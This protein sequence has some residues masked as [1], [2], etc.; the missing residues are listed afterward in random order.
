MKKTTLLAGAAVASMMLAT[1]A[2][3]A[4]SGPFQDVPADHW[5]Y[6]AVDNLQKKKIVIGYPDG[7]YGGK[8]AMTRYEFAV[9]IDRLLTSLPTPPAVNL[10]GYA[11]LTDLEPYAKKSD[12]AGFATKADVDTLRKLVQE[13]ETELTT[14]GVDLDK[15]KK[16]VD[17]LEGRVKAIETELKR[18]KIGGEFSFMGRANHREGSGTTSVIDNDGYAVTKGRGSRGGLLADSRVLHDLDL[19]VTAR[20]SD[21]ATAFAKINFGNY[22]SYLGSVGSYSG[23]RSDRV[24]VGSFGGQAVSQDQEQSVINAYLKAPISLPGV[25]G[26]DLT[27]GR[28]PLQLSPYTLK[29]IDVDQYFNNGKTDLGDIP[30]D[31]AKASLKL[32]P[33]G[34][35]GFAAKTDPI[36]YLSNVSGAI[37]GDGSYGLY[38]GAGQSPYATFTTAAASPANPTAPG[39]PGATATPGSVTDSQINSGLRG[40]SVAALDVNGSGTTTGNRPVGSSIAPNRNGA[41]AVEQLAGV[42]ASFGNE[43]HG[44]LGATY[45]AFAG[46]STGGVPNPF[47]SGSQFN[48]Q[49]RAYF[50]RVYLYGADASIN[51]FGIGFTGSYTQ[52][53][54]AGSR[55]NTNGSIDADT[56]TKTNRNNYAWDAAGTY[57]RGNFSLSA[58]YREVLPFFGAPGYWTRVGS[59]TNPTDIKGPY[60]NL[61]YS[62]SNNLALV[63]GGQFYEGT[64]KAIADGGLSTD[65]KIQNLKAGLKFGLTS[66]SAVDL[67]VERTQYDVLAAS[68][69]RGKP[70][71]YFYNIGYGYSF[72]PS[73]SFK[74]LYQIIRYHDKGTGFD[75]V[76]GNGGVAAAQFAVKF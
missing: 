37:T 19:N 32:G 18:V 1:S 27:I 30:V 11:K 67:G 57:A 26:V 7:T 17:A 9:A 58:G 65:D 44:S 20:L 69:G 47:L 45:I 28:L 16:Q 75:S 55:V 15:V 13:F 31:G 60:G 29:L 21:T 36:K 12:L 39:I 41:M 33:V 42:R 70:E 53:D 40:G 71:E 54:T 10:D 56:H 4:Q 63:V 76:N 49:D 14:L 35:T 34:I 48:R 38:A 50:D 8:R 2:A 61:K 22:L 68:G 43:K 73:S 51:L 24:A 72:N 3:Y 25:G 52:T 6:S 5:A 66:A 64:G 62:F 59:Y 23:V 46:N 74:V